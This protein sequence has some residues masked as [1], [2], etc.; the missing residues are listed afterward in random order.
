MTGTLFDCEALFR[1]GTTVVLKAKA[2]RHGSF[3]RWSGFCRGKRRRCTLTA[4]APKT[5]TALFRR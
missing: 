2:A 4:T 5:V 3:K 1:L